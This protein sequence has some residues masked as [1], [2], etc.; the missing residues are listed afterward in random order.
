[1]DKILPGMGDLLS[2]EPTLPQNPGKEKWVVGE[3]PK[4]N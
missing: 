1:M 2:S 4:E 3:A